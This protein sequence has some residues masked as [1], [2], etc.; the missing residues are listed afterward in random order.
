M[1]LMRQREERKE[2]R[3]ETKCSYDMYDFSL[4]FNIEAKIIK[5]KTNPKM[6]V[7][8]VLH[9]KFVMKLYAAGH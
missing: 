2:K 9:L 4:G 1:F 8:V 6:F 3:K 7:S 5:E